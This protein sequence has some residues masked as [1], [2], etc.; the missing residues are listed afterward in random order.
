MPWST[1][2]ATGPFSTCCTEMACR[3]H[4]STLR[5]ECEWGLCFVIRHLGRIGK[6]FAI[7][8]DYS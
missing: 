7:R 8:E 6:P 2:Q 4:E 1:S 5:S 3:R